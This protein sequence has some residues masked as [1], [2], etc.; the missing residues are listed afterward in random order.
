MAPVA[1]RP[2]PLAPLSRPPPMPA[3]PLFP[4]S[5]GN[6]RNTVSRAHCFGREKS[7][8]S[9]ANSVTSA[10]NSVSSL[11]NTHIIGREELAELSP[12]SSV[13]AKKLTEFGVR[14]RA[15]RNC[16]SPVSDS[17]GRALTPIFVS[18]RFFCISCP[19]I[20]LQ[21]MFLLFEALKSLLFF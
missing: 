7:P 21:G 20:C 15:L 8:S 17:N 12:R 18:L 9:A 16:I 19:L 3:A 11:W 5:V 4:P 10:K 1:A 14:N 6:G 2:L 13:R